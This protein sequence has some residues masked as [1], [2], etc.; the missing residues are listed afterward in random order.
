M[1]KGPQFVL[2]SWIL[3]TLDAFWTSLKKKKKRCQLQPPKN[4]HTRDQAQLANL[5]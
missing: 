4:T 5:F 3:P 1:A 2:H